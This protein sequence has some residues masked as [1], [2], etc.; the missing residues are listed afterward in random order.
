[1]RVFDATTNTLTIGWDHAE[2]PVR[3][4][5][6]AYAPLT[7]DPIT[8]FVSIL[9]KIYMSAHRTFIVWTKLV[10]PSTKKVNKSESFK[11]R[12]CF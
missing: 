8:E 6:I 5:K 4:Y 10:L 9:K 2:G 7:G 11:G 1:M 12:S 3:Q